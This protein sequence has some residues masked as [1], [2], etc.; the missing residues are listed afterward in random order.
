[1]WVLRGSQRD[2]QSEEK[3]YPE[4]SATSLPFQQPGHGAGGE[5]G[6]MCAPSPRALCTLHCPGLREGA[7]CM[8]C[9]GVEA[10]SPV[11]VFLHPTRPPWRSCRRCRSQRRS[12]CC[13]GRRPRWPRSIETLRLPDPKSRPAGIPLASCLPKSM[14]SF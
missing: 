10:T 8:R 11:L 13:Q 14:I 12:R 9:A 6:L 5:K 2:G 4:S 1:M 3:W 7:R